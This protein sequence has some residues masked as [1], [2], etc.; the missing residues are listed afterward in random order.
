MS[1]VFV[2][3]SRFLDIAT[4]LAATAPTAPTALPMPV[5][6]APASLASCTIFEMMNPMHTT[7]R[8]QQIHLMYLPNFPKMFPTQFVA[9]FS[10]DPVALAASLMPDPVTLAASLMPDLAL[11]AASDTLRPSRRRSSSKGSRLTSE[12]SISIRLEGSITTM[13]VGPGFF[14]G[15]TRS[16]SFGRFQA[17]PGVTRS[18]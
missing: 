10:P 9:F 7:I 5:A 18:V 8:M 2:G 1:S 12:L 4:A 6:T 15:V 3:W 17:F 16:V 11:D 14:S 13:T